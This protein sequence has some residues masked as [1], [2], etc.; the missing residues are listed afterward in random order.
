MVSIKSESELSKETMVT[1]ITTKILDFVKE[2][3]VISL[4][5]D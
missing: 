4:I 1:K 3:T 5:H 2:E